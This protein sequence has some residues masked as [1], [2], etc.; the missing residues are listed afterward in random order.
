MEVGG[1][2]GSCCQRVWA[3]GRRGNAGAMQLSMEIWTRRAKEAPRAAP[4]LP[5]WGVHCRRS[6]TTIWARKEPHVVGKPDQMVAWELGGS[7]KLKNG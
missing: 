3:D 7:H 2:L 6:G 1:Q 4:R 5:A